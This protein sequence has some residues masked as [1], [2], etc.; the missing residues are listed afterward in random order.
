LKKFFLIVVFLFAF[1]F[2]Q[3]LSLAIDTDI[4]ED[5][6]LQQD[7]ISTI[8][9]KE[10]TLKNFVENF[11]ELQNNKKISSLKKLYVEEFINADGLNKTQFFN[12]VEK[13]FQNYPDLKTV[14]DIK[15]IIVADSFAMIYLTQDVTATTKIPSKITGDKGEYKATLHS[16]LY[17]KEINNIWKIY[18]EEVTFENSALSFGTG[19]NIIASIN[20]PQKALADTDY[21][22]G[23][24]AQ[25]P[26]GFSAIAS[27]NNVQ[28]TENYNLKGETFRQIPLI[29]GSLE[30]MLKA[31]SNN[32]NEAVVV[33]VA[34][35]QQT[36]DMFKKPK[37][38]ISGLIILMKRVDIIP[39]K[40]S[41]NN[42]EELKNVQE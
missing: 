10:Q 40:T 2:T 20:A 28:I 1:V 27:I 13:T 38:D 16:I 8:D 23:V 15:K 30:R 26:N 24:S 29:E 21:C 18:S 5:T 12:L 9:E 42:T 33:S 35:T 39:Q 36:E 34:L 4:H 7:N 25:I 3:G 11:A 17:L 14:F 32:N 37:I 31:N 6:E 22:A 41:V 19:K